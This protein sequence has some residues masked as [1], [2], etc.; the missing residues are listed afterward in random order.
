MQENILTIIQ[1]I[2]STFLPIIVVLIYK[3]L[4]I[5]R[6]DKVNFDIKIKKDIVIAAV[7]FA[8]QAYKNC[9]GEE[10]YNV[11]IKWS[12]DRLKEKGISFSEDELRGLIE[13]TIKNLKEK[14]IP[15]E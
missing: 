11:A 10:R 12:I 3:K 13:S 5:D 15:S 1:L 8:E 4:G 9:N 6:M 7:Q 2:V 14:I